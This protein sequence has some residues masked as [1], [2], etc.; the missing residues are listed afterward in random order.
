M[1]KRDLIPKIITGMPGVKANPR[2][3]FQPDMFDQLIGTKG[4]LMYWS[5]AAICP[6]QNNDQTEQ[7]DPNCPLCKGRGFFY[8]VPDLA[9]KD[10]ATVDAYGNPVLMSA[11]GEGPAIYVVKGALTQDVQVFEK[12]GEWVFGTTMGTVQW[13]NRLGYRDRL[14]EKDSVMVWNQ[15]INCD[16]ASLIKVTGAF[17]KT[18]LRYPVVE[19]IM[20][21][22]LAQEY[23]EGRD[24]S[25]TVDGELEW[26]STGYGPPAPG[27]RLSLA[28]TIHP[29]WIVMEH[30]HTIRDTLVSFKA[31]TKAD[32]F[33][34][35]PVQSMLKLDFLVEP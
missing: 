3:D 13:Q 11:R 7:A 4:Y 16:G 15:V 12:F 33:R 29:V 1:S 24:F 20:F 5:R 21:R 8:Y 34:K 31:K 19:V 17:S 26:I 9:V 35:L 2:A 28:C 27:T 10:G 22:S 32:E 30:A 25:L 6:C 23:R 14:V 18:G